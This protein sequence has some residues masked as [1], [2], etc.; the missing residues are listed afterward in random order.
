MVV[1]PYIADLKLSGG[2]HVEMHG[3]SRLGILSSWW[4]IITVHHVTILFYF[5][6]GGGGE[7]M[8]LPR[9]NNNRLQGL[10]LNIAS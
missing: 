8:L 4:S 6:G 3:G 1:V 7:T 2:Y 9:P 5:L 10:Q